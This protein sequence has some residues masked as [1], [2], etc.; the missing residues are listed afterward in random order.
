[1]NAFVSMHGIISSMVFKKWIAV[2]QT[3]KSIYWI[4]QKTNRLKQHVV[5]LTKEHIDEGI[6]VQW[7]AL[8]CRS[9]S[10]D[11]LLQLYTEN[12]NNV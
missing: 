10:T 5:K 8:G 9:N 4:K 12:T 3:T 6:R 1:M 7:T 2:W 11:H